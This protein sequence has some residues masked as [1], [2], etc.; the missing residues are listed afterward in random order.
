MSSC[1]G[2]PILDHPFWATRRASCGRATGPD[3]AR[4]AQAQPASMQSRTVTL[5]S[6]H[7]RTVVLRS[8][9]R[10]TIT[11]PHI[12][13]TGFS[14]H[15]SL[16]AATHRIPTNHARAYLC[17]SKHVPALVRCSQPS[18]LEIQKRADVFIFY[19]SK[20][21]S[22]SDWQRRAA[23][24]RWEIL[25]MSLQY[26]SCFS[27]AILRMVCLWRC[28]MSMPR[29]RDWS[30]I[31]GLFCD[32]HSRTNHSAKNVTVPR[33]GKF[34]GWERGWRLFVARVSYFWS[35]P[36]LSADVTSN[37]I[38]KEKYNPPT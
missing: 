6:H 21:H 37:R 7:A 33:I 3:Q 12:H 1:F 36:G 25:G 10:C 22:S 16:W 17:L 8:R 29:P 26:F 24:R 13:L 23:R 30:S 4:H 15:A 5:L 35:C 28:A 9:T 34:E 2:P 27:F 38:W 14:P 19:S 20:P 32:H 31:C 18:Q 11:I